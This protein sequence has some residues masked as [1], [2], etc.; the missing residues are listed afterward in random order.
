MYYFNLII[1][2]NF[3]SAS[4]LHRYNRLKKFI[5]TTDS[6]QPQLSDTLKQK[7]LELIEK[8]KNININETAYQTERESESE[9][10]SESER[11]SENENIINIKNNDNEDQNYYKNNYTNKENSNILFASNKSIIGLLSSI[12]MIAVLLGASM[13]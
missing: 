5:S 4:R 7:Y 2:S 6:D 13:K 11:E 1:N 8:Y 12:S 9:N 3:D 10:E